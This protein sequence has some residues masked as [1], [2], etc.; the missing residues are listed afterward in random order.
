MKPALID[1]RLERAQTLPARY[2][3]EPAILPI[4]REK[5][6]SRSWQLVGHSRQ[7]MSLGDF[8]TT[9]VAGE[10]LLIVRGEDRIR[11]LS[12]V[13][14]HR[15]GP[16]ASGSG[17]RRALRCGYHGWAYGLDGQLLSSPEFE[18]VENFDPGNVRLPEWRLETWGPFLFV[19]LDSE[20]PSLR[21]F[22]PEV[23]EKT[24]NLNIEE[25]AYVE[26]REYV[27]QCNWKVYV[28][29][30]LEGY[31]IPIVHPG[32]MKEL[33][34]ARYRTDIYENWSAQIAPVRPGS[35]PGRR[36]LPAEGETPDA[37]YFWVFPNLMLNIYLDS[38]S[39]NLIVP[40]DAGRTLT[41]F[42]W[43]F[44]NPGETA[45]GEK[46]RQIID[47]SEEIQREDI[48]ICE[49]VQ[50]GLRS[51]TYD[52]GRYSVR[53]ENGVHHFHRLLERYLTSG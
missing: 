7:L 27:I 18:K 26:R 43:Y 5:I 39:T 16:V 24:E 42:E 44:R 29:N 53:R 6:F 32:L 50:R 45:A 11:A 3:S 33:D 10:P 8:F 49:A 34:Y 1:P 23:F 4:E 22:V 46:I 35:G 12:N 21:N 31:H 19:C 28:D 13:C 38:L 30:Y 36:Y 41:I 37:L 48:A 2:Y 51:K 14:R 25:M 9:E 52:R 17:N 20:V 47:F 40:L 15:A